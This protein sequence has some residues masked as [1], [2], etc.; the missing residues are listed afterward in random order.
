[1]SSFRKSVEKT[2]VSLKPDKQQRTLYKNNNIHFWTYLAQ[3]FLEWEKFQIKF[4]L[5]KTTF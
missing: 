1:L 4:F 5:E 2:H 3:F